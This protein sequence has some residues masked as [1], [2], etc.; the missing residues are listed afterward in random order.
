M[1]RRTSVLLGLAVSAGLGTWAAAPASAATSC[2]FTTAAPDHTLTVTHTGGI[3]DV[4][5]RR[6]PLPEDPS[7]ATIQVSAG[8]A[9]VAC[10]GGDPS[11]TQ[12]DTIAYDNSGGISTL[13]LIEPDSFAPGFSPE[14]G[15][16]EIETT[17]ANSGGILDDVILRDGDGTADHYAFGTSATGVNGVDVD[18]A[19]PVPDPDITLVAPFFQEFAAEGGAGDDVFS[20]AGGPGVGGGY[21]R[22]LSLAGGPGNDTL[23]GGSLDEHFVGEP[24]D[25][26][27]DGGGGAD[28]VSYADSTGPVSIDLT[29]AVQDG[30]SLGRDSLTRI[31]DVEGSGHNDVLRG[32]DG[33]NR[34]SG[35]DG[36]DVLEGRGGDDSL[37]GGAGVDTASYASAP[38]SVVV[39][40]ARADAQPTGG[41]GS[42]TLVDLENLT[43]GP[44]ADVLRGTDGA[45]VIEGG[46]G[47]DALLALGG[48]D[49]V[50]ARDGTP[51]TADCGAGDDVALVDPAGIDATTACESVQSGV[52]PSVAAGGA[53]GGPSG[54]GARH[55][56][57]ATLGGPLRQRL[58]RNSVGVRV[59]CPALACRVRV[60]GLV[61]VRAGTRRHVRTRRL[62]LTPATARLAAR[63]SALLRLVLP[64]ARRAP[65]RAALAAG[66]HPVVR[67]RVVVTDAAAGRRT[68]SRVVTLRR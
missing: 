40:L 5:V 62:A 36:D 24:G 39:D 59:G 37:D 2:A 17:A 35:A 18:P 31:E 48:A 61:T 33:P 26:V 63:R 55:R 23:T 30:G 14:A 25:D 64:R 3:D 12:V 45:N 21:G 1:T 47:A 50:L 60:T 49:R 51:D 16:S 19:D 22:R 8:V 53:A 58:V 13:I 57:S 46:P 54:P 68:L 34:L 56:V 66:R 6:V 52:A 15:T 27:I 41:A 42:D 44:G 11:V 67:V 32:D 9:P 10:A 38:S 4:T 43:G 28:S 65:V 7:Q 29:R 20:G